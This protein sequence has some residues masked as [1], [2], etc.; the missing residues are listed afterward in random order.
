MKK[1]GF[2]LIELIITIGLLALI[3]TVIAV[4]VMGMFSE[5][6]DLDYEA[7]VREIEDSACMYVETAF[8]SDERTNCRRNTCIVTVDML[9]AKGYISDDLVDPSTGELVIVNQDKYRVKVS[10]PGNVKTCEIAS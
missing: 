3:G 7:F 5:Q 4:N 10:W 6:E 9:L 2:T 8:S 1:N